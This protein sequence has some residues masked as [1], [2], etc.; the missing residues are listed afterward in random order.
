MLPGFEGQ[1]CTLNFLN[2]WHISGTAGV[3]L[4]TVGGAVTGQESWSF[5]PFRD[6]Y[7]GMFTAELG[8]VYASW[9]ESAQREF[10]CPAAGTELYYEA[11][12]TGGDD[13]VFWTT[14]S[15]VPEGLVITVG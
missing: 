8:G 6:V 1:N 10:V 7:V 3:Q 4:F 12:P 5:R 15:A 11:V 14:A 13:A 9:T 2:P